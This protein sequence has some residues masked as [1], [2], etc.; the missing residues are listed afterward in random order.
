M[1]DL[2]PYPGLPRWVKA[3]GIAAGIL[4]LLFII[5]M[6]AGGDH[7]PGRH[8]SG[9]DTPA[10]GATEEPAPSIGSGER[11]PPGSGSS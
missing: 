8:R 11:A 9:D 10:S 3:S 7:G 5:L 1:A 4:V 2:P 6:I